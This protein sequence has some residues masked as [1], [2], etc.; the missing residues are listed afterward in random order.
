M[1]QQGNA[2]CLRE[3]LPDD[4]D[5]LK[6]LLAH[7]EVRKHILMR[8]GAGMQ[9]LDQLVSRM[10]Y[11]HDPCALHLGIHLKG[12]QVLIGTASLQNWNR[13]EGK[14][15]LGYMIDP[16]WWGQGLASEAVGLLLQYSIRELGLVQ[17]EGRCRGDNYR[18]ERVMLNNGLTLERVMPM[19]DGSGDVMK[20]FTLLHN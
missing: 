10:L 9:Q 19:A 14:A 6:S 20:V 1:T 18:S 8:S 2:A 13:H 5:R 11:P 12:T 17:V 7:P 16:L 4:R 3:L 15:V